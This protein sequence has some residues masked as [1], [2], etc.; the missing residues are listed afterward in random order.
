MAQTKINVRSPYY[1]SYQQTNQI[2]GQLEIYIYTGVPNTTIQA[3]DLRY[4]L[5]SAAINERVTFEISELIKDYIPARNNGLYN[6]NI[7]Q[8]TYSTV[9]VDLKYTPTISNV[10]S[11]TPIENFG[12]RAFL[13]YGDFVDGS[14]PQNE[15]PLLQSNTLILKPSFTPVRIAIDR[16]L[17]EAQA[18]PNDF[19]VGFF[20][21]GVEI[22]NQLIQY[23]GNEENY[24]QI[25]YVSDNDLTYNNYVQ[26]VEGTNGTIEENQNLT[27]F[28]NNY[29]WLPADR[30]IIEEAD[31]S[32]V[33]GWN[34]VTS[35][36]VQEPQ[37]CK[38]PPT[39]LTFRNKFGA[40]QDLWFFGNTR[41][42]LA[43]TK[44][45]YKSN[46]LNS[47]GSY[48]T[49]NPQQKILTKQGQN[50][51]TLNSGWY[52][53]ENNQVFEELLLSEQVWIEY[54]DEVLGVVIKSSS[55]EYKNKLTDGLINYTLE[56]DFAFQTIN[57]VR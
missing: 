34:Y 5:E 37:H 17:A 32:P 21:N 16:G 47:S 25:I 35:I 28:F 33:G 38:Y 48:N 29:Q 6:P 51:L 2:S 14:N 26:Y 4:T 15:Q 7:A 30:I 41:K 42:T 8:E 40:L 18:A 36:R 31:A 49:Y 1:Y 22:L 9:Y 3:S 43:T 12:Y 55:F 20:N 19:R 53:E 56:I 39:K 24:K 57:N 46:I 10:P 50:S 13:G 23:N 54:E 52:P 45:L 44:T 27:N 11:T